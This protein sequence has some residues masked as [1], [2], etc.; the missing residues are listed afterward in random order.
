[1]IID[2]GQNKWML[3]ILIALIVSGCSSGSRVLDLSTMSEKEVS[4]WAISRISGTLNACKKREGACSLGLDPESEVDSVRVSKAEQVVTVYLS[5]AFAQKSFRDDDV[6]T[7]TSRVN[8]ALGS[9]L[10]SYEVQL[11]A[12]GIPISG[13]VPNLY[14]NSGR[15]LNRMPTSDD[16]PRRVTTDLSR[17]WQTDAQLSGRHIAIWPSHG[18][19]YEYKLDR[20]EWQRARLFQTVEDIFPMAFVVP[21]LMP[22]LEGAG[23]YVHIPR[24][25]DIQRNEVVVDND[26]D[27]G[28][29]NRFLE[30]GEASFAWKTGALPGFQN[31]SPLLDENPFKEGTYRVSTTASEATSMTAWIPTIPEAGQYAV[32]VSFGA[33]LN[34]TSDARYT[35]F[36]SGGQSHISVDQRM[37]GGTWVYLGFFDFESGSNPEI[38]RVELSNLSTDPGKTI[39]ADAV[40]FGGGVGSVERGGKTSGRPRF[41]E[42]ARYYMQYSGMPAD[43]VYNVTESSDDYI[44]DYRGRAEWVNYLR[45]A[46]SGP[47]KNRLSTGLYVPV[48]ISLAFHTDAGTTRSDS[49][50][51]TLMIYS[52]TGALG[53]SSFPD[54]MSRFAN[55]DLGDIM[56]TTIVSD[57]RQ[58]YDPEWSRRAIWD[59]DYSEAVRPN[60]PGVLL[61]L[62]SHQNFADMRFG[63]DPRFRFDV[64]R[65]IYKSMAYFLADQHGY[66]TVIQPLPVTHMKA[67]WSEEGHI[68]LSWKSQDDPLESSATPTGYVVYMKKG[69]AGFGSGVQVEEPRYTLRNPEAG[70][71]Y[72]FRVTGINAGGEGMVSEE[73]S[74]GRPKGPANEGTVLI[75]AGFDRVSAPASVEFDTFRGFA[76]FVDEGVADHHDMSF[77]G[78]QYDFNVDSPWSDDDSPGHGASYSTLETNV[79]PGNTFNYPAMHGASILNAGYVFATASDESVGEMDLSAYSVVDLI[80][81]E[82]KKTNGPGILSDFEAIPDELQQKMTAFSS[83]NGSIIITGAHVATDL[84]G[85]AADETSVAFAHDV[86]L[87]KWRTDHAVQTGTAYGIDRWEEFVDISFNVDPVGAIY[88]VESPD[89]LEPENGS[90]T[91]LRYSDNNMSAAIG[92]PGAGGVIVAGF[93]F[94]TILDASVRDRLMKRFLE[95]VQ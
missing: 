75:V 18:W 21:Y 42:G 68:N 17:P 65:S 78:T 36:H 90:K 53:D 63:L 26:T 61:E 44:D 91:L 28:I 19:Y 41:T 10:E 50:V 94:E 16:L 52:S 74:A 73:V 1:M 71:V 22:M 57:L 43:L 48:D 55:R 29:G 7:L 49:T 83:N 76:H 67:E 14:R 32:Y 88:R 24:E 4:N 62:L 8:A 80:L 66:S 60:V 39:S 54:G 5:K 34:A 20:W 13:L 40:R 46:P 86:L 72:S 6:K 27:Y 23:A 3:F 37:M 51:G 69:S 15:D 79:L 45:G 87:F 11:V 77:V 81:G 38:G 2:F 89:A 56:Q 47:N 30:V 33:E 95:F 12:L 85:P 84:A 35:V 9:G 92:K 64:A 58:K 70:A 82:E 25:R 93:P 31:V 59:R